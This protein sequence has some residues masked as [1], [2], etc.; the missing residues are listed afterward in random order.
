M[1]IG[2][3]LLENVTQL[4]PVRI[5]VGI[6]GVVDELGIGQTVGEGIGRRGNAL[7]VVALH[8]GLGLVGIVGAEV[9]D[10][11][12]TVYR[13]TPAIATENG[14]CHVEV[15]IVEKSGDE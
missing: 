11:V 3:V 15:D 1:V 4:R 8:D 6:G 7:D 13:L 10:A 14:L 2:D 9:D 12:E 5:N